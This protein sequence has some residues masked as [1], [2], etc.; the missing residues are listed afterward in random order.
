MKWF[1]HLTRAREDRAIEKLIME[2]GVKGY[3]LYFYCLE[4]I[5]GSVEA[6]NISFELEPDAEI[7]ARRLSMDTLEVERIMH[8][9]I[10]L[11]LF[12]IAENGRITCL[13][14]GKFLDSAA[15]SNVEVRKIIQ[16][17][18]K[19]QDSSRFV[20]IYQEHPDQ[21]RLEEKR[22]EERDIKSDPL[23]GLTKPSPTTLQPKP[24]AYGEFG[25]VMLYP[26]DYEAFVADYGPDTAAMMIR[27]RGR[28]KRE[29][30]YKCADDFAA[31]LS[32]AE[33]DGVP[34]LPPP[35]EPCPHCGKPLDQGICGNPQC[36]QYK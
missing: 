14:L 28:W 32:W 31:L 7:L 16:G 24:Q 10:E 11:G 35:P 6:A 15:T 27:K 23:K 20:K 17:W 19:N 22:L 26:S 5:A 13:K 1:R 18:R 21:I 30:D 29:K 2:Y 9:C 12:E 3:G 4:I 34:K 8:R 33:K 25:N 36:P